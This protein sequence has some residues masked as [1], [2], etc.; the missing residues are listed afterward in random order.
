MD[1]INKSGTEGCETQKWGPFEI[2]AIRVHP[3][4]SVAI[5]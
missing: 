4:P 5:E 3:C 1:D 2:A